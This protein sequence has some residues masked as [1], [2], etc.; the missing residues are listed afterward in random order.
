MME[1]IS[2]APSV[3]TAWHVR[4]QS[5]CVNGMETYFGVM[6][7]A[8]SYA[9]SVDTAWYVQDQSACCVNGMETGVL[10]S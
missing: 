9:P 7:E 2:Y 10:G 1:A 3:D 5:G 4:D 8:M 6:M